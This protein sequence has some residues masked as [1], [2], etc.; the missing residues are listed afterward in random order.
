VSHMTRLKML[1]AL[2]LFSLAGCSSIS[3]N[4]YADNTPRMVPEQ[5][6]NGQLTAHGVIKDRGGEVIRRFNADIKAYW[7]KGV[8]TLEEDFLFDDGETDRRVWTLTP[9]GPGR[10]LGTAGDVVGEGQVSVAGNSM[11]L[12][13]VLRIPYGDGTLDLHIDDRMYLVSPDV[14]INE[15]S[16]SKFGVRVGEILLVIQRYP[17]GS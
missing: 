17:S 15:S 14:L 7:A 13:Y 4:E 11:F 2:V 6:F 9:Q 16:M 12:D 8:G 3:V 1:G 10:Y 5:F